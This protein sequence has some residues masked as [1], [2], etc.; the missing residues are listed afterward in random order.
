[1][2]EWLKVRRKEKRMSMAQVATAAGI[3][4]SYYSDIENDRRRY[5]VPVKTAR[6]IAEVLEVPWVRFYE[7]SKL[8]SYGKGY[9]RHLDRVAASK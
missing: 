9:D 4:Q 8:S 7:D 2:R 6:A 1:M 5:Q 3:S